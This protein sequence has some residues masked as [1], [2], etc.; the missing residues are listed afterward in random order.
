MLNDYCLHLYLKLPF[1]LQQA[2]LPWQLKN[3]KIVAVGE[4][5]LDYY[6]DKSQI[7]LQKDIFEKQINIAN[8][9][10]TS[11][12]KKQAIHSPKATSL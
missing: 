5:G 4:I 12:I 6:W 3:P 1:Y 10:I 8:T 11:L 7:E 9:D 2:M